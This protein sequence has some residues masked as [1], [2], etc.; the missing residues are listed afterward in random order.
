MMRLTVF[1]FFLMVLLPLTS[2]PFIEPFNELTLLVRLPP[3]PYMGGGAKLGGIIG[4][5]A[6]AP[7]SGG[8]G[9]GIPAPK[10]RGASTSFS[11]SS[12]RSVKS[13]SQRF[14]GL[15]IFLTSSSQ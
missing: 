13:R 14:R 12:L 7:P 8:G 2:S 15:V 1:L 11:S 6:M 3:Y 4:G 10:L 5:G 9:G